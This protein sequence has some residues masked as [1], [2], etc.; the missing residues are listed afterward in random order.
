MPKRT[1][2]TLSMLPWLTVAL[3][4]TACGDA[5]GGCGGIDVGGFCWYQAALDQSCEDLCSDFGGFDE[6]TINWAGAPTADDRTNAAH[7]EELAVAFG[8]SAF[9]DSVDNLNPPDD[10]GCVEHPAKNRSALIS[11]GATTAGGTNP[12]ARRFCACNE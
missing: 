1:I 8:A 7:C 9:E 12:F 3:V 11:R 4:F 6:A 10:V 5:S 2:C